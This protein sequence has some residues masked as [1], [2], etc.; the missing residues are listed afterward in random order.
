MIATPRTRRSFRISSSND[1]Q[2]ELL[3]HIG[4]AKVARTSGSNVLV[5]DI[6]HFGSSYLTAVARKDNF[7]FRGHGRQD[8]HGIQI[9]RSVARGCKVEERT[10]VDCISGEEEL[11][12]CVP[13]TMLPSV[14]P[15]V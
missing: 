12:Q 2:Q 9:S 13:I 10:I 11:V 5:G 6:L 14:C 7:H 15:G 3:R 1:D 4:H 8:F